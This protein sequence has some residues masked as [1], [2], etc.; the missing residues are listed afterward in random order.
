MLKQFMVRQLPGVKVFIFIDA[1]D[2]CDGVATRTHAYFWRAVTQ[3]AYDAKAD[4]HVLLSRRDFPFI[5]LAGCPGIQV[6][7]RNKRDISAYVEQRFQLG[8]AAQEPGWRL[9]RDAISEKSN[10][11]FLWAVLVLDGVMGEV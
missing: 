9:L 1:L 5:P 6:D 2:E 7:R 10:G 11:I 4:L 3:N 8:I